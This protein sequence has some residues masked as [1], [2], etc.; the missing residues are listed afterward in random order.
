M[1]FVFISYSRQDLSYVSQ[2]VQ[3]LEAKGLPFWLDERIE[4]SA[5]WPHVIEQHV[6][7]CQVFLL[8]M[9][10]RSYDSHWVQCELARAIELRKPIFP[11][12]LEGTRWFSVT[13]LQVRDVTNG[14]LPP[15]NFFTD[16]GRYFSKALTTS[17]TFSLPNAA[18]W[19][20]PEL[21]KPQIQIDLASERGSGYTRL[22]NLLKAGKWKEADEETYQQVQS[23]IEQ[24]EGSWDWSK[25][26]DFPV[27]VLHVIDQLW[28]RYSEQQFGFS[29]QK[30]IYLQCHTEID[31]EPQFRETIEKFC[32][33]VSWEIDKRYITYSEAQF[34]DSAPK[35]HLPAVA[36]RY[37]CV[38]I[39]EIVVGDPRIGYYISYK[40]EE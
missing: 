8:V 32:D 26:L 38:W 20:L 37:N 10:P 18:D 16:I 11:L 33:R 17:Q 2:L 5:T 12:L 31:G 4:H 14:E 34:T 7:E 1:S 23:I 29:V 35:G 28:M 39:P 3:A 25:L 21:Y 22:Q 36:L 30:D 19:R 15:S 40:S 9:T 6:N 24:Q 27:N 13:A